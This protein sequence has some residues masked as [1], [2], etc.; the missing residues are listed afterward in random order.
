MEYSKTDFHV[1]QGNVCGHNH[2]QYHEKLAQ[3][4]V[5]GELQSYLAKTISF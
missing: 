3:E 4:C 5:S 1:Q 2:I